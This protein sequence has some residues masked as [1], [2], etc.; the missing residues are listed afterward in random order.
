MLELAGNPQR[1][2]SMG[3]E[4]QSRLRN[5]SIETAVDGIIQALA[6]TVDPRV[7]HASV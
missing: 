6:A 3:L 1:M 7:L 4:A 2:I 5:Y